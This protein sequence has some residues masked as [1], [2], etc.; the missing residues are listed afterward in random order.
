[1]NHQLRLR[2][3][4]YAFGLVFSVTGLLPAH[5]QW[6][7]QTFPLKAGW[8]AVYLHVDLTH[9]TVRDLIDVETNP[10]TPIQEIWLWNPA[11]G[12]AQFTTSPQV[13]TDVGSQWT[14]WKR[15]SPALSE[16]Q[17]LPGNSACLIRVNADYVWSV[18]GRPVPPSYEWTGSGLN[19]LGIAATENTPPTFESF[20]GPSGLLNEFKIYRYPAGALAPAPSPPLAAFDT[21]TVRRGEAMWITAGETFGGYFGPFQIQLP[22]AAGVSFGDSIGQARLRIRN[23]TPDDLTVTLSLVESEAPPAGQTPIL[24]APPLLLRGALNTTDLTYAHSI[25]Q[26]TPGTFPLKRKGQAGSEAEI[27]LGLNRSGMSGSAGGLFAG[28]L[29]F[30]DSLNHSQVDVP[31]SA[32]VAS[33]AGLWVGEATVTQVQHFLKN[34]ELNGNGTPFT[35]PT[36]QYVVAGMNTSLGSVARPLPLR[37]ILHNDP[38]GAGAVLLQR[39]YYGVKPG[40][41]TAVATQQGLL[42]PALLKSAR[43]I[44]AVHLPWTQQNTPW[45]L[46]GQFQ[47]DS[48]LTATVALP[49]DDQASNPFLHTYHPDHDNLNADFT[50][51][52]A[53]GEESYQVTRTITLSQRPPGADFNSLTAGGARVGGDYLETITLNGKASQ[54]RTFQ[55]QG[56]FSLGRVSDI[57][58][59]TRP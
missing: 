56:T 24:G 22:S 16:L 36:G 41:L 23:V 30:T 57:A 59:L 37:L 2:L 18:R 34:Y 25:L 4:L 38:A 21:E 1:M 45:P 20:L 29:R 32:S 14:S 15:S 26:T 35:S 5:A 28:V 17:M 58:T 19:F 54:S 7:T 55:V 3:R 8:N 50:A 48:S 44:S 52:V 12:T 10:G 42:D 27:V 31:V 46:V 33:A 47:L 40:G 51:Q 43:R 11:L 53:Q 49:Y 13:P 9:T 39:V 6:L